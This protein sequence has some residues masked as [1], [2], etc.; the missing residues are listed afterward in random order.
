MS[1]F[2]KIMNRKLLLYM[3]IGLSISLFGACKSKSANGVVVSSDKKSAKEQAD[4]YVEGNKRII[5]WENEE[6]ELFIKR[7][8]WNMQR[9]G[10]GMYIEILDPGQGNLFKEGD[11]VRLKYQTFLLSGEE[12]YNSDDDG[13]KTFTVAKSEEIDGLHEAAQMLRPGAKARLVI[14]SYLAYGVAGDGK[15]INGRLALAMIIEVIQ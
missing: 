3:I 8:H 6:I 5:H 9:T 14:P 11:K 13:I 12:V 2:A 7:Y 4:P 1:V 10:T 15:R